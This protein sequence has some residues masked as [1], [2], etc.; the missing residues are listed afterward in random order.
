LHLLHFTASEHSD[1][2]EQYDMRNIESSQIDGPFDLQPKNDGELTFTLA[3]RLSSNHGYATLVD[4]HSHA[5]RRFKVKHI[6]VLVTVVAGKVEYYIRSSASGPLI[7][8]D[9]SEGM[10][11]TTHG[12]FLTAVQTEAVKRAALAAYTTALEQAAVYAL[13]QE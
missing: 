7:R 4:G 5:G 9:G 13:T 8:K 1:Y 10:I 11:I 2:W 12:V 3:L 6:D